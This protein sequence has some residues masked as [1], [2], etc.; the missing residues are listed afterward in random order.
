MILLTKICLCEQTVEKQSLFPS[1]ITRVFI[2]KPPE[3]N[4]V[5][6]VS[7]FKLY[8]SLL[9]PSLFRGRM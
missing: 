1:E 2:S 3:N 8:L 5:L 9:D 4:L 6:D 7:E